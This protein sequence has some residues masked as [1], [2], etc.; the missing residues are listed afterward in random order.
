MA[1][2]YAFLSFGATSN[3]SIGPA[4]ATVTLGTSA[5]GLPATAVRLWNNGTGV[6]FILFG[7]STT[8]TTTGAAANGMPIPQSVAP[9]VLRT[10]GISTFQLSTASSGT[11]TTTI[12][13]TAGEGID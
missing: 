6:A 9:F 5:T 1:Q 7:S 10:G 12:I 3:V 8:L 2:N 4:L 13:A 11:I